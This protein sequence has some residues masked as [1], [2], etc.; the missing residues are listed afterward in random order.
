MVSAAATVYGKDNVMIQG[1]IGEGIARYIN[2]L[3]AGTGL[4]VGMK[5][6]RTIAALPAFGGFAA[7][8]HFWAERWRSTFT[9]GYL[10]VSTTDL[11]STSTNPVTEC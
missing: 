8:Q 5:S 3:G 9:Y 11:A 7:Y 2:D 6:E 4:D 10:Q 1:I